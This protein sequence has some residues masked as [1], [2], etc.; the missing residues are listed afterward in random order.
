MLDVFAAYIGDLAQGGHGGQVTYQADQVQLI[1]EVL[2]VEQLAGTTHHVQD[3]GQV[4][5]KTGVSSE[6]LGTSVRV[7]VSRHSFMLCA[8]TNTY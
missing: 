1:V 2:P 3:I 8:H 6:E 7:V 5:F 4:T